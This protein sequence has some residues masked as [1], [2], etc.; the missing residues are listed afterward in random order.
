MTCRLKRAFFT[1]P[2]R[3]IFPRFS[4]RDRIATAPT[5]AS[6]SKISTPGM[7]CFWGKWP[8]KNG[9]PTL[10]HLMPLAHTPDSPSVMRST[11]AKG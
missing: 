2:N 6:A 3:A 4:V 9:S 11:S 8:Q 7:T 10:T 5:W 1:P